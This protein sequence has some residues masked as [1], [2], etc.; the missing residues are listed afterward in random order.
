MYYQT[1]QMLKK[2]PSEKARKSP[3]DTCAMVRQRNVQDFV[4]IDRV[5]EKD[6]MLYDRIA[7]EMHIYVATRAER[8]QNSKHWILT[9]NAKRECKRLHDE[10]IRQGPSKTT[11]PSL[12]VNKY[13]K[14]KNNSSKEKKNLTTRLA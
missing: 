7:L 2:G 8:I 6:R 1:T 3:N 10:H 4:V 11:E 14:E 12:A 9:L 13:D 5:K